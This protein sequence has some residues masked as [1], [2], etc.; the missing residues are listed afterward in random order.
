[1]EK[2]SNYVAPKFSIMNVIEDV[3]TTSADNFGEYL[4]TCFE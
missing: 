2:R 3:I 1:M 4:Q